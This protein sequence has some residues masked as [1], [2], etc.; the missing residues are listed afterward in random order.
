LAFHGP[1]AFVNEKRI[2]MTEIEKIV[3]IISDVGVIDDVAIFDVN[4]TFKENGVDSLDVF[5]IF[6]ALEEGLN[7][8]FSEEDSLRLK[9][10]AE[11]A[12]FLN[13]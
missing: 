1:V 13:G 8:K 7:V 10:A 4:K 2:K 9:S 11:I 3:K 5:T 12:N 6:L